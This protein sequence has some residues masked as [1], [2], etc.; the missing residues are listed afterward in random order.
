MTVE[1]QP[2]ENIWLNVGQM[3]SRFVDQ[4]DGNGRKSRVL[5]TTHQGG[6]PMHVRTGKDG[7]YEAVVDAAQAN[8]AVSLNGGFPN[9]Y[10]GFP[11]IPVQFSDRHHGQVDID[12]KRGTHTL[13]GQVVDQQG[14]PVAMSRVMI[15]GTPDFE[16]SAMFEA[17]QVT[18]QLDGRFSFIGLPEGSYDV[19]AESRRGR[20]S[21][22]SVKSEVITATTGETA[23]I[24]LPSLP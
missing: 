9:D 21:G 8:W 4:V 13:Q 11:A 6:S 15:V 14:Q 7:R 3:Q 5:Q 18:T 23:T 22:K 16:P 20:Q 10:R 24:T 19:Y 17:T 2:L 12:L 1:G